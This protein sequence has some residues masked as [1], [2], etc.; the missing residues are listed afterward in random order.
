[1]TSSRFLSH[2]PGF[3]QLGEAGSLLPFSNSVEY[4]SHEDFC[5]L[6][7]M[8]SEQAGKGESPEQEVRVEVRR[9]VENKGRRGEESGV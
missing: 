5:K 4:I 6:L 1:M 8:S 7:A 9:E 3:E 2:G